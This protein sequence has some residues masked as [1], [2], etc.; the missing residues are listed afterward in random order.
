MSQPLFNSWIGA[1]LIAAEERHHAAFE[2]S[3]QHRLLSECGLA[4]DRGSM[5]SASVRRSLGAALIRAGEVLRGDV[6]K[7]ADMLPA[8]TG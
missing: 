7:T 3:R 6:V 5:R 2:R 4:P 8:T 1:Q